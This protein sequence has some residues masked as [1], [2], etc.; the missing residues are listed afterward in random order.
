MDTGK[1]FNLQ[2]N[3]NRANVTQD[4][5]LLTLGELNALHARITRNEGAVAAKLDEV[6]KFVE[7]RMTQIKSLRDEIRED[8]KN[9]RRKEVELHKAAIQKQLAG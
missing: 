5:F 8:Q 1:E 2:S 9:M 7:V 6:E 4:Y 3:Q